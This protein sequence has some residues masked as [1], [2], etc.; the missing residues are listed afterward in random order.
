MAVSYFA[1]EDVFTDFEIFKTVTL[2]DVN[3]I[4]KKT[5]DENHSVLSVINPN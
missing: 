5:L 2:D 4:F 1:G 3:D